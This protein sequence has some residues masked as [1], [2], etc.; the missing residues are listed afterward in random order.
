MKEQKLNLIYEDDHFVAINK[1]SGLLMH[2]SLIDKHEKQTALTLLQNEL[3]KKVYIVHRL[4]KPTAGIT[5]FALS[6][7]AANKAADI[8]ERRDVNKTYL[9]IVRGYPKQQDCIYTPLSEVPDKILSKRKKNPTQRKPAVTAF[10]RITTTEIP[11]FI[12]RHPTSRYSLLE[13]HP[14][15]GRMHQIRRHLKHIRYPIIGDTKH[16]DH[17]HNR[18]FRETLD[19]HKMLLAATELSFLH[20]YTKAKIQITASLDQDF[21]AILTKFNWIKSVPQAWL[22]N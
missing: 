6:A 19:C 5:L 8:F 10:R 17:K 7:E 3:G 21:I 9:A 12:S 20:P 22:E 13:V 1:P 18:Y 11:V 16:G 15:T 2:P 14:K 4:D